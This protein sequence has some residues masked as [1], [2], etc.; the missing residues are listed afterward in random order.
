WTSVTSLDRGEVR[1]WVQ[2][3]Y[4]LDA[5]LLALGITLDQDVYLK[6][7]HSS[8]YGVALDDVR[9]GQH[10]AEGP[11]VTSIVAPT[12]APFNGFDV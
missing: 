10:D 3:V 7:E 4:D 5:T 6:F 11:S 9:I 1:D 8:N 2:Y 12:A